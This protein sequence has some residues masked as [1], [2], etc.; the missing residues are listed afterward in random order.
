M[1]VTPEINLL[2][3]PFE[4]DDHLHISLLEEPNSKASI[5]NELYSRY[6]EFTKDI[7][8]ITKK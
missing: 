5:M 7:E 6:R 3:I 4:I 1:E 2:A 8:T